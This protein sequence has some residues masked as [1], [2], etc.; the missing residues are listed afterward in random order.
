MHN[1]T[2]ASPWLGKTLCCG[3]GQPQVFLIPTVPLSIIFIILMAA[4]PSFQTLDWQ[5]IYPALYIWITFSR[6]IFHSDCCEN[7]H[8]AGIPI[9]Y[10]VSHKPTLPLQMKTQMCIKLSALW[11]TAVILSFQALK[12]CVLA[13]DTAFWK[14]ETYKDT[15]KLTCTD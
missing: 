8:S 7:V 11:N 10:S 5:R 13:N 2:T 14:T 3:K 6:F 12:C 15:I 1:N 4:R 9:T